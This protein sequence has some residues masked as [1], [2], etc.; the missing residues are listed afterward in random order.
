MWFCFLD[1][2]WTH[3]GKPDRQFFWG[4]K[5]Q[6]DILLFE[7]FGFGILLTLK[8]KLAFTDWLI[9]SSIANTPGCHIS[10]AESRL[11]GL[12]MAVKI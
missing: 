11:Y 10:Y 1:N 5:G 3:A 7:I 2:P 4:R 12:Q 9:R 8:K 6:R